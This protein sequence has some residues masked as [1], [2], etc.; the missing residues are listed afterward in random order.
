MS[1]PGA[2][3]SG[4]DPAGLR[5]L[6]PDPEWRFPGHVSNE[7]KRIFLKIDVDSPAAIDYSYKGLI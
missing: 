6:T 5:Q 7:Q 1:T 2:S 3:V 4:R